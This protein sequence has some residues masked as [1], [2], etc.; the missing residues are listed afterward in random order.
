MRLGLLNGI[1]PLCKLCSF[2]PILLLCSIVVCCFSS[3]LTAAVGGL[4]SN[5]HTMHNSE[6]GNIVAKDLEGNPVADAYRSLLISSC[7]GCHTNQT[8][9]TILD[10]PHGKT[11]IVNNLVLPSNMLAGGNFYYVQQDSSGG[12]NVIPGILDPVLTGPPGGT[13]PAGGQYAGQLRCSG[14]RGCHGFNGGHAETPVDDETEALGKAHHSTGILNG[15][16]VGGS[17]R[18]LYG[19][20]GVEDSD[21][22]HDN[23]NS[24]HNEYKGSTNPSDQNS[25]SYFC[26][27]CHGNFHDVGTSSPWIR[28]PADEVLPTI[29]AEY[30]QYTEYSM[31]APIARPDPT[32]VSF[33]NGVT[34]GQD[35]VMCLSCHR[36]HGSPYYKGLRWDYKN[37]NLST[38]LSGCGVCHTGKT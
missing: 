28:H 31:I 6:G 18:F 34:P 7:L 2:A 10:Q 20:T 36:A 23:T 17:Y 16:A 5:C 29:P 35:I 19:I 22:E 33:T 9:S 30:A 27:E 24:S 25:I 1:K 37:S 14:T 4:C 21:W 15:S 13:F 26:S 38:A 32:N 8:D 12:H 11:P 3:S